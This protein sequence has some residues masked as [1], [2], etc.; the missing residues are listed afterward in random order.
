MGA[1]RLNTGTRRALDGQIGEAA[2]GAGPRREKP[3]HR[4]LT[5]RRGNVRF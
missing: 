3:V 4:L 2:I 5:L 1:C